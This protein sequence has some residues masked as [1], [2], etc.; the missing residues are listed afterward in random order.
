VILASKRS[1]L[2]VPQRPS[3]YASSH[4]VSERRARHPPTVLTTS[5]GRE[6]ET[7]PPTYQ[8]SRPQIH[9]ESL[10]FELDAGRKSAV[11]LI[12]S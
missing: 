11:V 6:S 5:P 12:A 4:L 3:E 2:N 7:A 9:T 10:I 8:I 1:L